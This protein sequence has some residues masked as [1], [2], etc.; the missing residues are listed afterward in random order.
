[1]TTTLD[2]ND[3]QFIFQC[4]VTMKD[5]KR[6]KVKQENGEEKYLIID[7]ETDRILVCIINR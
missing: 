3:Y 5:K 6:E 7:I 1:M 4:F 2:K